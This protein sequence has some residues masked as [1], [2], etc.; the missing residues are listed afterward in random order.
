M[1]L[2]PLDLE[3]LEGSPIGRRTHDALAAYIVTGQLEPGQPL[4]DRH[5]AEQLGVSRTPVREALHMLTSSG[6]VIRSGRVG[7]AVA[8][9]GAESVKHVYQLRRLLEPAGFETMD[10]W[11]PSVFEEFAQFAALLDHPPDRND[12]ATYLTNDRQLHRAFVRSSDNSLLARFYETVE[13]Q[14][15][16]VR[17]FVPS[18]NW[19]RLADSSEEHRAILSAIADRDAESAREA[20]QAHITAAEKAILDLLEA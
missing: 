7:W 13:F 4:S 18:H 2:E 5:L 8:G 10:T 6:L 3:A 1:T 19:M 11:E 12:L 9:F 20:L 17:H 16:R 15:D 14:I